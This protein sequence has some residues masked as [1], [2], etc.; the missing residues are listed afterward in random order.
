MNQEF[1]RVDPWQ[2]QITPDGINPKQ[3]QA[4]PSNPFSNLHSP[5]AI[6]TPANQQHGNS[7]NSPQTKMIFF[8][9][10]NSLQRVHAIEL[11]QFKKELTWPQQLSLTTSREKKKRKRKKTKSRRK[12]AYTF[13]RRN[14]WMSVRR[15][16]C[17]KWSRQ[18]WA[19]A[20]K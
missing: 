12:T 18:R 8:H 16:R 1:R 10:L 3:P 4:T 11:P 14:S 13:S 5:F 7:S 2:P 19:T 17:G 20:G 15:C 6:R 9:C